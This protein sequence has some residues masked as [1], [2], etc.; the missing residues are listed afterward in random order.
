[1]RER[2]LFRFA[3]FAAAHGACGI[4]ATPH[5]LFATARMSRSS[6]RDS[7]SKPQLMR[8]RIAAQAAR[9]MAEDGIADIALAKR[10]AARQLGAPA[11]QSLPNNDEV[12]IQLK[13][14]R[15]LY[16]PDQHLSLVSELRGKALTAML[17][18]ERFEPYLT[19]PVLQGTAGAFSAIK[20]ELYAAN[21]KEFHLFLLDRR[22]SFQ[23]SHERQN[24]GRE[25]SVMHLDW[26]GSPLQLA[27][28]EPGES[29][30]VPRTSGGGAPERAGI[31]ALERLLATPPANQPE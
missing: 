9:L 25:L 6:A 22:L 21:E 16:Q 27:L 2:G 19:G 29:R 18:F 20:L 1:M 24:R 30:A 28:Y 14:Y 15:Q 3:H 10:K 13:V 31:A 4:I 17:F 26:Q 12:E 7:S 11:T 5:Y 8:T 23:I